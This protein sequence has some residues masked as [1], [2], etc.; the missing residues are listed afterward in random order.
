MSTY[1]KKTVKQYATLDEFALRVR[2]YKIYESDTHFH[3]V[4]QPPDEDG[5][6]TSP[7]VK[8]PK[9]VWQQRA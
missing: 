6:L 1:E 2:C 4:H 5:I 7:Y 8:N 3:T 9:L